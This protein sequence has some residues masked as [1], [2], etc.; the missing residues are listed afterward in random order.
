LFL[1]QMPDIGRS[2]GIVGPEVVVP[3][4]ASPQD[5]LLGA[6]GRQP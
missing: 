5:C 3:D 2:A 6:M 4:D 1:P